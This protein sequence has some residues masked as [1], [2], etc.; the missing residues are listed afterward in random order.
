MAT[1]QLKGRQRNS[2][3]CAQRM[4]WSLKEEE[5]ADRIGNLTPPWKSFFAAV[6]VCTAYEFEFEGR[7][8]RDRED[9]ASVERHF[10]FC[11]FV[12]SVKS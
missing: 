5:Q 3:T 2:F 7:R 1:R 11:S 9:R 4:S 8:M 12:R 10:C 6:R